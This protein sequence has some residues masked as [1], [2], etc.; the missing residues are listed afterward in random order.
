M[1]DITSHRASYDAGLES[2]QRVLERHKCNLHSFIDEMIVVAR[3]VSKDPNNPQEFNTFGYLSM[4]I[5]TLKL[6][7]EKERLSD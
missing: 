1:D 3:S 7:I 4:L 5:E 2:A 6:D